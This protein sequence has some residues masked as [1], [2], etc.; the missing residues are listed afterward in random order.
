MAWSDILNLQHKENAEKYSI[1]L[2]KYNDSV[3]P[4]IKIKDKISFEKS[5][6]L[7]DCLEIRN[8]EK[9]IHCN[10]R[11]ICF[12]KEKYL[13]FR[14]DDGHKVKIEYTINKNR[15][16]IY[17][18]PREELNTGSTISSNNDIIFYTLKFDGKDLYV[19]I[20]CYDITYDQESIDMK[21]YIKF[22]C[23]KMEEV[24]E[25]IITRE[26]NAETIK[27]KN[28][29]ETISKQNYTYIENNFPKIP[30]SD[31]LK[32]KD[33]ETGKNNND[34]KKEEKSDKKDKESKKDSIIKENDTNI[35]TNLDDK[36]IQFKI[37]KL[38]DII[39]DL[40]FCGYKI[41]INITYNDK[42][43]YKKLR[44]DD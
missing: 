12:S 6:L 38:K 1:I 44:S 30:Y 21:N 4:Q 35:L 33:K 5:R 15:H 32:E 31:I 2:K 28:N 22:L 17:I 39:S 29:M 25:I 9:K 34:N 18:G 11:I 3:T 26:K 40:R 27:E 42:I 14:N 24:D 16:N 36:E 43:I 23:K 10:K 19:P 37:E 20:T 8:E 13:W 7:E 41:Q